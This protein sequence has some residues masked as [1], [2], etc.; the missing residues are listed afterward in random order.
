MIL[1]GQFPTADFELFFDEAL[2]QLTPYHAR[3]NYVTKARDR[4]DRTF[5]LIKAEVP[6]RSILDVGASPFYLLYRAAQLGARECHGVYFAYDAHPLKEAD[7][8]YS[9]AA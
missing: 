5:D 2:S 9:R 6:G 3:N 4:I 1:G 8:I 7:R